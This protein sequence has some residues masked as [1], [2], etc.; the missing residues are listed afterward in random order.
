MAALGRSG[1]V[2][3]PLSGLDNSLRGDALMCSKAIWSGGSDA[4]WV[5]AAR[6]SH[7]G[8]ASPVADDCYALVRFPSSEVGHVVYCARQ[9]ANQ[10]AQG[11]ISFAR[12]RCAALPVSARV[13]LLTPSAPVGT[14]P[15]RR[16]RAYLRK[17]DD[18]AASHQARRNLAGA[19]RICEPQGIGAAGVGL[20]QGHRARVMQPCLSGPLG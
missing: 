16:R 13:A 9:R 11:V 19:S 10:A 6:I 8:F 15:G 3:V 1:S 20:G 2:R 7:R 18:F 17:V 14:L 12:E 4:P 5:R